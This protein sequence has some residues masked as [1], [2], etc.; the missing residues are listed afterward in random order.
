MQQLVECVLR[1]TWQEFEK[2]LADVHLELWYESDFRFLFIKHLLAQH[3]D[4]AKDCHA[5]WTAKRFDLHFQHQEQKAVLEF[6]FYVLRTAEGRRKGGPGNKNKGEFVKCVRKLHEH[7]HDNSSRFLVLVY[8]EP[9]RPSY[10]HPLRLF[11]D[12]ECE[13]MELPP[14]VVGGDTLYCHLLHSFTEK[15]PQMNAGRRVS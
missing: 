2:G 14:L 6:K 12:V 9:F 3:R 13:H 15:R 10:E 7:Q 11:R 4:T 5:E 1:E 8:H